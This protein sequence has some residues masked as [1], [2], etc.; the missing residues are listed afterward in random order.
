MKHHTSE[1]GTVVQWYQMSVALLLCLSVLKPQILIFFQW[2]T[3]RLNTSLRALFSQHCDSHVT[4][5]F[6]SGED[7]ATPI[8]LKQVLKDT[9]ELTDWFSLGIHLDIPTSDLKRIERDYKDPV[10]CK[11]EVIDFWL[12][13]DPEPTWSKLA[14]AVEDI[15]GHAKVVE[16][17][18]TNHEGL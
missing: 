3:M 18:W 17:L 13:N 9:E 12:D 7:P 4:I 5:L 16:T 11:I 15:G 14:H 10:R 1:T 2:L 6:W 8:S